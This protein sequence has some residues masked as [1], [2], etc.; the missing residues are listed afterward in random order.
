MLRALDRAGFSLAM[1]ETFTAGQIAARIA[2]LPGAE[3]VFRRGIV[4]RDLAQLDA[5]VGLGRGAGRGA[6]T[7]ET[8]AA[9]ARAA[10]RATG[11]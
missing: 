6:I 2:H 1:A 9:V 3:A 8:A 10:R 4:A 5:A 7:P 11:A